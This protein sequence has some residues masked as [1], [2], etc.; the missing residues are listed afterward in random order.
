[1]NKFFK[2][3]IIFT[4]FATTFGGAQAYDLKKSELEKII[5]TDVTAQVQKQLQKFRPFEIEVKVIN[6]P[7]E[8]ITKTAQRPT[9]KV[10]SNFDK[11]MQ[12]DIKKVTIIDGAGSRSFPVNVKVAVYKDVLVAREFIPQFQL[13]NYSN[14][15]VKKLDVAN[16]I[17]NVMGSLSEPLV[18]SKNISRDAPVLEIYTKS[19]PDVVRNSDVKVLFSQG[20]ALSIELVGTAM[21][22]GK[23]GD[24]ITVKNA[25]YNKIYTATVVGE[26]RV[27][28]KL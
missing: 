22:E 5:V 12:Y 26:N 6:L 16:N 27:E 14:T 28:V 17:E 21:K 19:R 13:V 3:L 25:K 15:Y 8:E 24:I 10:E 4:L 20:D 9:V 23:V 18:A 7:V 1:M 2:S 11:F